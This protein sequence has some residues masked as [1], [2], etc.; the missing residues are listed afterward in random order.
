MVVASERGLVCSDLLLV[1]CDILCISTARLEEAPAAAA[2]ACALVRCAQRLHPL[3]DL[4]PRT[5][6]S[7]PSAF[8]CF[9]RRKTGALC[10]ITHRLIDQKELADAPIN[11][12]ALALVEIRLGETLRDALCMA[13]RDELVDLRG[14]EEP[15]D[16]EDDLDVV[17]GRLLEL[18]ELGRLHEMLELQ[19]ALGDLVRLAPLLETGRVVLG[20][21]ALP[22]RLDAPES[23][24]R[25]SRSRSRVA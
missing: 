1:V 12:D 9:C 7:F 24:F 22:T 10:F 17:H 18:K 6:W 4:F 20:L 3:S 23:G 5:K 19:R 8:F 15:A 14:R 2:A 25:A 16:V 21:S 13:R 11:A